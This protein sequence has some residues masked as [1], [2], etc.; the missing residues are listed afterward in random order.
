MTAVVGYT[1]LAKIP[2]MMTQ[3]IKLLIGEMDDFRS[4]IITGTIVSRIP[5]TVTAALEAY[6]ISRFA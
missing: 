5:S 1:T 6:K 2:G 4:P 3:Y